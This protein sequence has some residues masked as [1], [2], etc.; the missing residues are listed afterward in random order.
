MLKVIGLACMSM[1]LLF[2]ASPQSSRFSGY[3]TVEAYEI[4]PG[5]L[6][7]PRY[8][9]DGQV[10]EIGLERRHYSPEKIRLDSSL[11]REEIDRIFE[12]LV[13]TNERGPKKTAREG[14]DQILES[15]N[16]LVASSEYENVS[17]QIYSAVSS[18]KKHE[19]VADDIAAT[20]RWN[21]RK[22]R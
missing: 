14:G 10:C 9:D 22:C 2:Y 6:M 7:M 21:N 4:R 8:A 17:I 11:S 3:K 20:L 1:L 18:S 12:E 13:P 15:G 5:I 19:I 16:S